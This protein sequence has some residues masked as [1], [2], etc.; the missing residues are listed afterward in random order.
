LS[1][2]CYS[3]AEETAGKRP[4]NRSSGKLPRLDKFYGTTQEGGISNNGTVFSLGVP[5]LGTS[6]I[7]NSRLSISGANNNSS[8]QANV[9]ILSAA[10][11]TY[12]LQSV[13]SLG[14]SSWNNVGS[15]IPSSGGLLNLSDPNTA[16]TTQRF[17]RVM[18]TQQ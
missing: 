6:T 12:Q 13:D 5:S 3:R 8:S 10:G 7:T 2:S 15:S 4:L 11:L 14:Q 1:R 9:S 18:I 17:Y 16:G